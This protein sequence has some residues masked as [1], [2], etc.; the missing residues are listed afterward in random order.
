VA[1]EIDLVG[2]ARQTSVEQFVS[3]RC[4]LSAPIRWEG[5]GLG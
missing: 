5:R 1:T 2:T 3:V 4:S